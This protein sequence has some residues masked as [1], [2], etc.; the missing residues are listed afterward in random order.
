MPDQHNF[1][2]LVEGR[3]GLRWNDNGRTMTEAEY[4]IEWDKRYKAWVA[5]NGGILPKEPSEE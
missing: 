1:G 2:D 3:E 5:A 4:L